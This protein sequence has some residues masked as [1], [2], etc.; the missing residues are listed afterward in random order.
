M[1]VRLCLSPLRSTPSN[2]K[3]NLRGIA[4]LLVFPTPQR[5]WTL[6]ISIFLKARLIIFRVAAVAMPFP[7]IL[8]ISQ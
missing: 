8:S 3:P 7:V 2:E 1:Y 6:F 4:E 5:I